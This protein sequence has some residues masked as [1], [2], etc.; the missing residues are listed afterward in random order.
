VVLCLPATLSL[1]EMHVGGLS[2]FF[3]S[4]TASIYFLWVSLDEWA[5]EV[6]RGFLCASACVLKKMDMRS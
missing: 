4:E 5:D 1:K 3:T 6:G 2:V